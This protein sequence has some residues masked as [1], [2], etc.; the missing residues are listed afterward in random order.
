MALK[1]RM[2]YLV[3]VNCPRGGYS[4]EQNV[5]EMDR[6]T[7]LR[8]IAAGQYEDISQVLELNPV[9]KICNDVTADICREI[10][11]KWAGEGEPLLAWQVDF[12]ESHFGFS[13]ANTFK[14]VA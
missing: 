6:A 8:D 9:E 13:A 14:R 4:P 2:A 5:A 12:I 11:E 1:D 3:I 7:V 10:M